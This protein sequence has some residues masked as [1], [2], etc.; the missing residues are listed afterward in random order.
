MRSVTVR[1]SEWDDEERGTVLALLDYEA[2]TCVGCGGYLPETTDEDAKFDASPPVRCHRCTALQVKQKEYA[3]QRT[4]G[5]LV[6]WPVKA[7]N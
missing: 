6:M 3:D 1:E 7:K 5:A 2:S 4:P